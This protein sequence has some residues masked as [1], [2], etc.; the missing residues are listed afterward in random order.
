MEYLGLFVFLKAGAF[1]TKVSHSSKRKL[2][3]RRC[4]VLQ[5]GQILLH[6]DVV[7]LEKVRTWFVSFV[8][9]K[10]GCPNLFA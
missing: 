8:C 5:P 7:P 10:C 3:L 1:A 4:V 6:L 2:E 9:F